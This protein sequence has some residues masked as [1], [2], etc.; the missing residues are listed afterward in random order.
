[1][2]G[3]NRYSLH[4]LR[5]MAEF[6][7]CVRDAIELRCMADVTGRK[8]LSLRVNT[9]VVHRCGMSECCR[10]TRKTIGWRGTER[11][12]WGEKILAARTTGLG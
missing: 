5:G 12:A 11:N 3:G 9:R 6:V 7:Q 2:K 1:M 4:H 8:L 10:I